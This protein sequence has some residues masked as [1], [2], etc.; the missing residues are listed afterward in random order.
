MTAL[1]QTAKLDP[2]SPDYATSVS[3][4]K[5]AMTG[6][7]LLTVDSNIDGFL[8]NFGN[9]DVGP[10][11]ALYSDMV[12][13][14]HTY[15][16]ASD[17]G[18]LLSE[19][20]TLA[21]A[22]TSACILEQ[23]YYNAEYPGSTT[24]TALPGQ[25]QSEAQDLANW[26]QPPF[27]IPSGLPPNSPVESFNP[28]AFTTLPANQVI[29]ANTSIGWELDT[30]GP[31]SGMYATTCGT[32]STSSLGT[33]SDGGTNTD[34]LTY[35]TIPGQAQSAMGTWQELPGVAD[36][37]GFL[38]DSNC[39]GNSGGDKNKLV[40]CLNNQGFNVSSYPS[41]QIWA[42]NVPYFAQWDPLSRMQEW[43]ADHVNSDTSPEGC[44]V[45]YADNS[46]I[47]NYWGGPAS[48]DPPAGH[49]RGMRSL[50]TRF[51]GSAGS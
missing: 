32:E 47:T 42:S 21:L 39:P 9:A 51:P 31:S 6:D 14:C 33:N 13:A 18:L 5:G 41:F 45:F 44:R 28:P 24:A 40:T 48:I 30:S 29:D 4:I 16:N 1:S 49:T 11:L 34:W 25:C 3:A 19:W 43:C 36:V 2:T 10:G 38:N 7:S 37:R 15:F 50:A 12:T 23:N 20:N 46:D 27:Q 17:S 35:C 8:T 26:Y 22:L